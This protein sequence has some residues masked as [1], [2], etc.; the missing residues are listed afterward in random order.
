VTGYAG[1]DDVFGFVP[2]RFHNGIA[3]SEKF[4]RLSE[5]KIDERIIVITAGLPKRTACGHP[6][7]YVKWC[8][9]RLKRLPSGV[10]RI[11][12]MICF[13]CSVLQKHPDR[14]K[15][16]NSEFGRSRDK[17]MNRF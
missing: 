14:V 1:L 12:S 4:E 17:I 11:D 2:D 10:H 9:F 15:R 8:S 5:M 6:E 3:S 16:D 13:V 7:M